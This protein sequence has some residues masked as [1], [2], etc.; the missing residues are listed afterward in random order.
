MK[1]PVTAYGVVTGFDAHR[2]KWQQ[3]HYESKSGHARIRAAQ[4]RRLGF[5]VSV[6]P[7]GPQVTPVGTVRMTMVTV[8]DVDP[9]Q[10]IPAPDRVQRLNPKVIISAGGRYARYLSKHLKRE[11][12]ATRGHIRVTN[13]KRPL[14]A[15]EYE[16]LWAKYAPYFRY[17]RS[18]GAPGG[19]R[20][21][22]Y[23]SPSPRDCS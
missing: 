8:R 14:T 22:L 18:K 20:C 15:K 5:K 4:L 12:P 23:T 1:N 3:E 17:L 13:P 11:H 9:D 16:R 10:S 6:S 2:R 21:L 7:L 19:G